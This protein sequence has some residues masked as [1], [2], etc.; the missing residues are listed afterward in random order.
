M[1][2]KKSNKSNSWLYLNIISLLLYLAITYGVVSN[3][4]TLIFIDYKVKDFI[5]SIQ[6]PWLTILMLI[7][8]VITNPYIFLLL[9]LIISYKKKG[10]NSTW[11][12]ITIIIGL[13][14]EFAIK[15]LIAKPR[16]N[17]LVCISGYSYS[18]PSGHALI[19]VIFFLIL[20][21]S[22]KSITKG[23]VSSLFLKWVTL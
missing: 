18:F 14:L 17:A 21:Y 8:S 16:P 15:L 6:L 9:A 4:A 1:N 5:D 2:L 7:L 3:T 11:L 13:I 22:F 20:Y 19:S 23:F 10:I 12:I